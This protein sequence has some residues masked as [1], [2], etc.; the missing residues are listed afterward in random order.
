MFLCI[1]VLSKQFWKEIKLKNS[2]TESFKLIFS[3]ID[4]TLLDSSRNISEQTIVAYDNLRSRIPFVLIS[5]RQPSAMYY[6]Q[7]DLGLENEV[8]VCYNGGMIIKGDQILSSTTIPNHTTCKAIKIAE[9]IDLHLSLYRED[10]WYAPKKDFWSDREQNNTRVNPTISSF[11]DMHR[12]FTQNQW[13]SH[14]MMGMGDA[15]KIDQ[16]ISELELK[17]PNQLHCYRSKDTYVEIAPKNISKKTAI[18]TVLRELYPE[19][20]IEECI[21]FGDNFNDMEMLQAVG[22][23]VAVDNAKPEVKN[24]ADFLTESNKEHGVAKFLSKYGDQ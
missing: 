16:L 9:N 11:E 19:I 12:L 6:L 2:L 21:A 24:V 8:L 13:G 7:K 10:D 23:G 4:G 22:I 17:F 5:S 3:D 20:K 18:Q 15:D 1:E 14:K